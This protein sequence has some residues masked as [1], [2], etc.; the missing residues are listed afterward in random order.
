MT[1]IGLAAAG[2]V[3][4]LIFFFCILIFEVGV[5]VVEVELALPFGLGFLESEVGVVFFE[6][7]FGIGVGNGGNE[8]QEI[9]LGLVY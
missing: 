9:V 1:L 7:G 6:A 5:L 8:V 2:A 3:S 4:S